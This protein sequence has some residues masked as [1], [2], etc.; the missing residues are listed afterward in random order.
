MK[1][2]WL[3]L[4]VPSLCQAA[5][6]YHTSAVSGADG[7]RGTPDAPF[8]TI[9]RGLR[10]LAS[11]DTLVIGAGTYAEG[12][13]NAVPAGREGAPTIIMGADGAWPVL[14]P[15]GGHGAVVLFS[16]ADRAH[17]TVTGLVLDARHEING[18][19]L[20]WPGA[21]PSDG[22][23]AHHISIINCEIMRAQG[24]GIIAN[25]GAHSNVFRGLRIHD[26]GTNDFE[27]GLYI[28]ADD[29]VIE[30]SDIFRNAGWGV[31]VYWSEVH[32]TPVNRATVRNNRIYDNARVGGRGAGFSSVVALVIRRTITSSG[33]TRTAFRCSTIAQWTRR[34]CIIRWCPTWERVFTS[35]MRPR[36]H[37]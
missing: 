8:R 26:N 3:F 23:A 4:L 33:A 17:I 9:G 16:G 29:N 32:L 13:D 20:T 18:V 37:R 15:T 6:T 12:L 21:H 31:Q 11:G 35:V 5:T 36:A 22:G 2:I 27:H 7:S 14:Q 1:W 28:K 24:H 30:Q 25:V 19:A 34:C 10:A